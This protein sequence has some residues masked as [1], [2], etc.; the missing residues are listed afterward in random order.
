GWR[1]EECVS[2][3]E[4]LY[5][6]TLGAAYAGGEE[7]SKGSVTPGKLADLAVLDRNIFTIP[8]E[9]ILTTPVS[10]TMVGGEFVHKAF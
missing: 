6:Y 8:A 5:A 1:P 3:A 4:A 2:V 9:E 10:A 7:S